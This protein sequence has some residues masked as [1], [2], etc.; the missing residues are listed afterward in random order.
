MCGVGKHA[1]IL[2]H[3]AGWLFFSV[4]NIDGFTQC[5]LFCSVA[6]YTSIDGVMGGFSHKITVLAAS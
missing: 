4:T 5:W 6:V 3:N 1:P 2:S